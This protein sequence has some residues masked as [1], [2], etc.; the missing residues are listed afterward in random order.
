MRNTPNTIIGLAVGCVTLAFLG[1]TGGF[2]YLSATGADSTEFRAFL[3]TVLQFATL[4]L[5][6][7]AFVAAGSAAKSAAAAEKQTNGE[8]TPRIKDAVS[9]VLDER[10]NGGTDNGRPNV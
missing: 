7:G 4:L 6:G 5:G 8:L 3:D 10:E 2:V 9:E 1:V